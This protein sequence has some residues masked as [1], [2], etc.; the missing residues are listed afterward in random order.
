MDKQADLAR[1]MSRHNSK[2]ASLTVGEKPK[3][4]KRPSNEN[5]GTGSNSCKE[6][7]LIF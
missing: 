5:M 4:Q 1:T 6:V 2:R 3:N 7:C